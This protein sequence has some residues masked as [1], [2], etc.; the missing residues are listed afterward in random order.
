MGFG[1][2][3]P[4]DDDE[5]YKPCTAPSSPRESHLDVVVAPSPRDEYE[6]LRNFLR[7][8]RAGFPAACKL[9]MLDDDDEKD[10]SSQESDADDDDDSNQSEDES[11]SDYDDDEDSD[12]YDDDQSDDDDLDDGTVFLRRRCRG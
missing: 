9:F 10:D 2:Q 3:R 11:E 6:E 5:T 4:A 8:R 12:D 7:Q 1:P